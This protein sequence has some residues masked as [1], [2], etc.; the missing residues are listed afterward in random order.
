MREGLIDSDVDADDV[1]Y[2]DCV[3]EPVVNEEEVCDR[4]GRTDTVSDRVGLIV[5]VPEPLLV[6][7]LDGFV[8]ADPLADEVA[9]RDGLDVTVT[10]PDVLP[11]RVGRIVDVLVGDVVDER[12]TA[13]DLVILELVVEDAEGRL[14]GVFVRVTVPVRLTLTERDGVNV[15]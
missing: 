9:L 6:S 10:E 13:G 11:V 12:E 1:L 14:D 8:V 15:I 3:T 7:D 5:S 4:D 2:A